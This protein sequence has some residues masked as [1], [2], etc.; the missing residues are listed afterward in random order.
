MISVIQSVENACERI[1]SD[2]FIQHIATQIFLPNLK[3]TST[4]CRDVFMLTEREYTPIQVLSG[5][6]EANANTVRRCDDKTK[7]LG[8]MKAKM[9]RSV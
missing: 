8:L 4:A 5:G 9:K 7:L 3:A 6:Q 1:I 2:T